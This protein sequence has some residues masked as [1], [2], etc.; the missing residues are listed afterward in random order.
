LH[1]KPGYP[2]ENWLVL[3]WDSCSLSYIFLDKTKNLSFINILI[4]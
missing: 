4:S 1:N 3:L 2:D